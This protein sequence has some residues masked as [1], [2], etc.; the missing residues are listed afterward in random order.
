MFDPEKNECCICGY[1]RL[2]KFKAQASDTTSPCVVNILECK[3]CGFAWQ[4]PLARTEKQSRQF[5][6]G[7]YK[8][9]GKTNT[10]YFSDSRKMKIANLELGFINSLPVKNKTLLD[11]GAGSGVFAGVASENNWQ[12]TALDPALTLSENSTR[13][14][15]YIKGSIEELSPVE[16]YDVITL[17]DVIEHVSDPLALIN[18]ASSLL[19]DDGYLVLETGNYKSANRV[20]CYRYHW[21]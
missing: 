19:K 15:R 20:Y 2:L 17:W 12:V 4:Y 21:T 13:N 16:K 7:A 3:Q 9:G 14:F 10:T 6:E 8:D 1:G 18:S 11:V 5:F